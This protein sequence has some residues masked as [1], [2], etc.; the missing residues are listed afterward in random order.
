M[1]HSIKQILCVA[2]MAFMFTAAFAQKTK[3]PKSPNDRAKAMTGWM[4]TNLK[5]NDEQ[6]AKVLSINQK[7]ASMNQELQGGSQSKMEKMKTFKANEKAKDAELKGVLTPDQYAQYQA[8]KEAMK[9]KGKEKMKEKR[10]TAQ[11]Q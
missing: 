7:Y 9:E 8:K 11:Q 3:S 2:M 6:A 4:K 5:L 10:A 1:N